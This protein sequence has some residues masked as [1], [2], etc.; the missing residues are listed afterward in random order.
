MVVTDSA[1]TAKTVASQIKTT[2]RTNYSNPPSHGGAIV[3]A[4]LSDGELRSQWEG[5]LAQMRERIN[6]MRELYTSLMSARVP[7]VDFS[8]IEN[9]RGMFSYSGLTAEQVDRLREESSI[10]IVRSGRINVAGITP[11]NAETL[12]DAIAGVIRG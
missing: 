4:I 5:E 1:E 3:E 11:D 7:D 8:F 12:C 2:I 10:Y 6:G 9:Q